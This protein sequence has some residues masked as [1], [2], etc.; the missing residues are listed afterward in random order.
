MHCY[1]KDRLHFAFNNVE[2]NHLIQAPPP[3]F[4][5]DREF[6]NIIRMTGRTKTMQKCKAKYVS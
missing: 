1:N 5:K 4:S 3:T 6:L 2:S